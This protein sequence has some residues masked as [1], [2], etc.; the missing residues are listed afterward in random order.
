M[1]KNDDMAGDGESSEMPPSDGTPG[2]LS[3]VRS[4]TRAVRNTGLP[5]I[6]RAG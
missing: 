2:F 4:A 6:L 3:E 1:V 5:L